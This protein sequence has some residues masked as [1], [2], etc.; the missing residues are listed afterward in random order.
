MSY[1]I[2][3]LSEKKEYNIR[4]DCRK[5]VRKENPNSLKSD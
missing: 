2:P 1:N 4:H 5:I 3:K